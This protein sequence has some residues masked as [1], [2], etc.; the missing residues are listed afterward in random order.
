MNAGKTVL[1]VGGA[2]YIGS[3]MCKMLDK[4]GYSVVVLDD[5]STSSWSDKHRGTLVQG[6][7]ADTAI[8]DGICRDHDIAA[9]IHFAACIDVGESVRA[10]SKYY[11]NNV[12]KS[13]H[14]LNSLVRNNIRRIIFSSTASVYGMPE[15]LPIPETHPLKPINPYGHSKFVIEQILKY[16]ETAH[17]LKHVVLRYFNAAGGDPEGELGECHDPETHL[18]PNV[19]RV[20]NG[21][22]PHLNLLGTSYDTPDGSGVRDYVHVMDLCAGHLLALQDLMSNGPSAVYN[23]GS[24]KGFSVLEVVAEVE[25][26]TGKKIRVEVVQP[27]P[28]EPSSLVADASKAKDYLGWAPQ[29]PDLESMITHAYAWEKTY[30]SRRDHIRTGDERV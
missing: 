6:D 4:E 24:E 12:A 13:I 25:R 10:P 15:N 11:E 19:L 17:G 8:V 5:L 28:G 27:R 21:R 7:M 30:N 2:G 9:V 23:L 29:Y 14:L 26:V 1:V 16:Y 3:H 18:I 20:A 22:L